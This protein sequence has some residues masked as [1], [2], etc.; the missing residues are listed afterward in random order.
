MTELCVYLGGSEL[1]R[2]SGESRYFD[3]EFTADALGRYGA[4]SAVLSVAVLA[5]RPLRRAQ[6]A[7]RQN[8]FEELLPEGR[9]REYLVAQSGLAYSDTLGILTR[10]GRDIAGALEIWNPADPSEPRQP[11]LEPVSDED[12]ARMLSDMS[13]MPLGNAPRGGS[14][15]VAGVQAKIVLAMV[16]GRWN[17]PLSGYPSSHILKSVDRLKPASTIWDEEYGLQIARRMG[18]AAFACEINE[19][20]GEPALVIERFDRDGLRRVHQEDFNQALGASG[21]QKYQRPT[22]Q[23]TLARIAQTVRD[24]CQRGDLERLARRVVL[25][26]AVGDLDMHAKN[27]SL[28]HG[29][30]G[31]VELAPAYDVVP[32]AHLATDGDMALAVDHEYRHASLTRRHLVNEFSSWG[33]RSADAVVDRALNDVIA[34][35][36]TCEPHA[37]AHRGIDGDVSTFA[38]N[39]IAGHPTGHPESTGVPPA[40]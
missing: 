7:R 24:F 13:A 39:L 12:I 2:I 22:G 6:R 40:S 34:A 9:N 18:L 8:F 17:R 38:G 1:G 36:S 19:F 3:F 29:T 15:S 11:A 14:S 20:A 21:D 25:A 5:T 4:G 32:Q 27:M 31:G 16:D 10:Y 23:V 37:R 26:V 35:L 30:D 28:L 33:L